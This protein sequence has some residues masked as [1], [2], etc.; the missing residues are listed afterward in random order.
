MWDIQLSTF[1]S[2]QDQLSALSIFYLTGNK[3]TR[4]FEGT[5]TRRAMDLPTIVKDRRWS[6]QHRGSGSQIN[7]FIPFVNS[8]LLKN[9]LACLARFGQGCGRGIKGRGLSLS[10][11]YGMHCLFA[12]FSSGL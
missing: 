9:R 2:L 10:W 1:P 5:D 3:R 12:P 8:P 7:M 4:V 11:G 6:A